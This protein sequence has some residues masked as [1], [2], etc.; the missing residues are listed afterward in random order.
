MLFI[1]SQN[2][3]L[4]GPTFSD[5]LVPAQNLTSPR[6]SCREKC[7][8][9]LKLAANKLLENPSGPSSVALH[10]LVKITRQK[11]N[12]VYLLHKLRVF[13]HFVSPSV[14]SADH[15]TKWSNLYLHTTFFWF[16]GAFSSN[17]R[18]DSTYHVL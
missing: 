5:S 16:A 8:D 15:M 18:I 10:S 13:L 6:S 7:T 1:L 11:L 9:G 3:P 2:E 12:F 14:V 17:M 4:N